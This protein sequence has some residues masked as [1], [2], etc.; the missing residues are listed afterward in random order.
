MISDVCFMNS[1]VVFAIDRA[2]FVG[3]DGHTHHGLLDISYLNSMV[4]M[5]VMSPRD[6]QD[7]RY[8][9]DYAVNKCAGPVAV[10]YPR[11]CS[12]FEANGPLYNDPAECVLPHLSCGEGN[13]FAI[14]SAGRIAAEADKAVELLKEK[15]INGIHINLALIKPVPFKELIR[16]TSG[17]RHVFTLEE[18]I[19]SGGFGEAVMRGFSERNCPCRVYNIAVGDPMIRAAS[20]MEQLKEAGIDSVSVADKIGK[21]L[22]GL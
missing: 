17:I 22:G 5:T 2:G 7:L 14:V 13:D 11:G 19:Q 8:C 9:L 1:H 15:G 4:N 18:G 3:S 10:R 21:V 12:P 20:P 16:M 6:Y